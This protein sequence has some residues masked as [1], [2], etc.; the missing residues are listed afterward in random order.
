MI[1]FI[2]SCNNKEVKKPQL[3]SKN[4]KI[5]PKKVKLKPK[6]VKIKKISSFCKDINP[7]DLSC[8]NIKFLNTNREKIKNRCNN[9]DF[10][11]CTIYAEIQ[12]WERENL[13][14]KNEISLRKY[15]KILKGK[16]DGYWGY[17]GNKAYINNTYFIKAFKA[18]EFTSF[19][20]A[21]IVKH[22]INK[23]EKGYKKNI[24]LLNSIKNKLEVKCK[25]NDYYC[26]L[27]ENVRYAIDDKYDFEMSQKLCINANKEM[28]CLLIENKI[29]K[30]GK[31]LKTFS[32]DKVFKLCKQGISTFCEI[33][34]KKWK[35]Y[36]PLKTDNNSTKENKCKTWLYDIKHGSR[37]HYERDFRKYCNS[38]Y[39]LW[40]KQ[41]KQLLKEI[42][43]K[44]CR[45]NG[46]LTDKDDKWR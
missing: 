43:N 20:I 1:F 21:N 34:R 45:F 33:I 26:F 30:D 2:V 25:N 14:I 19:I 18:K 38:H 41:S 16:S 9:K 17:L 27:L 29:E 8:K 44:D 37:P 39:K 5:K 32:K 46:F 15:G 13:G 12:Y 40:I 31:V 28:F 3:K 7:I 6:K 42:N 24:K 35:Y 36:V 10:L 22:H 23:W 11:C 4:G